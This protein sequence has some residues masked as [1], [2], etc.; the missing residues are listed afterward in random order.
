MDV[1]WEVKSIAELVILL[2]R[3]LER[4]DMGK[5]WVSKGNSGSGGGIGD[6]V[7]PSGECSDGGWRFWKFSG[8]RKGIGVG[9]G[10]LVPKNCT[11]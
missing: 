5:L 1:V 8:T 3:V 6:L 11:D 4:G 10:N 9:I 2:V 7:R